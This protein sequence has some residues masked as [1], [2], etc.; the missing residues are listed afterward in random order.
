MNSIEHKRG[1]SGGAMVLGG[2]SYNFL[3]YGMVSSTGISIAVVLKLL[4]L[5]DFC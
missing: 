1:W 2:A 4:D 5:Y 3:A